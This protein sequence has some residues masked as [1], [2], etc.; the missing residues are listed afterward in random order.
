MDLTGCHVLAIDDDPVALRALESHLSKKG[1]TVTTASNGSAGLESVTADMSV[2]L[3]D[4]RM[5]GLSGLD[6]LNYLNEHHPTIAV[7]ILTAS[8]DVDSAVEAMK[9]GAL[10]YICLLY[11]SDAADE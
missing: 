3:I 6:C 8:S 7:I 10:Q 5:P 9:Q 4:L 11:T 2:A 1:C